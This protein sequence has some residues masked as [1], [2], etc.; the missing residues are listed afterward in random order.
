M[1]TGLWVPEL[2]RH[3]MT[4]QGPA[5]MPSRRTCMR[6]VG[7]LEVTSVSNTEA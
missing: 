4:G 5:R 7:A 3:R 2:R 1:I 6:G